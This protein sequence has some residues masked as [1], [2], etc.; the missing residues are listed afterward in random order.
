MRRKIA[1]GVVTLTALGIVLTAA[2]FAWSKNRGR[3]R[4]ASLPAGDAPPA[5]PELVAL[6]RSL[7]QREKC[8][9][10]HSVAGEGSRRYPLDG[11]GA[12]FSSAQLRLWIV[13]PKQMKSSVRKPSYAHLSEEEVAALVAYLEGLR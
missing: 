2:L 8:Q 3:E 11:A 6:G 4:G 13:A 1:A 10:C 7:F 9:S 5:S 12:R